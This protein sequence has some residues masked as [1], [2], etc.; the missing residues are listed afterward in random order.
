MGSNSLAFK[1]WL[2]EELVHLTS[3]IHQ[4]RNLNI[5]ID[6]EDYLQSVLQPGQQAPEPLLP[7]HGGNG[8]TLKRRLDEDL[9]RFREA[10]IKPWFVFPGLDLP[11]R[12]RATIFHESQKAAK[13]LDAAWSIYD[14][15]LGDQAVQG[16]SKA[17][18]LT[19]FIKD[20]SV[21][22]LANEL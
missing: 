4:V 13:T 12:D 11:S 2:R 9:A 3:P 8:F 18:K 19:P 16:F 22:P 17:C 15:G 5:G 1:T 21:V 7:A 14:Q 10:G 6:A 20:R